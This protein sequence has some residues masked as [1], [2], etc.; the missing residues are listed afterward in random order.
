MNFDKL[1]NDNLWLN[2]LNVYCLPSVV[3]LFLIFFVTC[4]VNLE[5]VS[6]FSS[7]NTTYTSISLSNFMH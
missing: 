2:S 7:F 6:V 1:E 5:I 4:S 3:L